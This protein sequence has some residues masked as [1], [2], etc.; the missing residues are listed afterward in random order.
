M[1]N[2]GCGIKFSKTEAMGRTEY[3]DYTYYEAEAS[4]NIL[5][6]AAVKASS[7]FCM[8]GQKVGYIGYKGNTLTFTNV[9]VPEDGT[10]K[11][12]LYYC[13]GENRKVTLKVNGAT[14]YEMTGLNSGDF[15]H[16]AIAEVKLELKA[17][18][19]TIE[20]SNLSYYAPD[21]DRIAVSE[22]KIK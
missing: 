13:S 20:F 22:E 11:L 4:E 6:G 3:D 8:G 7:A 21:I 15:V 12:L 5:A 14:E 1:K 10:Y 19:N 9:S 18:V 2:G 16:T 17:G